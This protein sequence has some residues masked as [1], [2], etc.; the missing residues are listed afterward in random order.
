MDFCKDCE[1]SLNI[2]VSGS[3]NANNI[4]T[5]VCNN[6]HYKKTIDILKEPQ[7]KLV[8]S[9]IYNNEKIDTNK[10][11]DKYL[12]KDNTLPHTDILPCPNP[13]CITNKEIQQSELLDS[14]TQKVKNDV[15]Y[16]K[17]NENNLTYKYKCCNCNHT[18]LNK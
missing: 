8:Y 16:I 12:C 13:E 3:D 6:C 7:Y 14:E 4:L 17:I 9:H 18:W 1:N 5:F 2:K 11:N 10:N 15:L